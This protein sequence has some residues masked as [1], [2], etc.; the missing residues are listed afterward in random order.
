MQQFQSSRTGNPP[1]SAEFEFR[2]GGRTAADAIAKAH[3][4]PAIQLLPGFAEL[5]DTDDG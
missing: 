4:A 2:S 5:F 1:I 3:D